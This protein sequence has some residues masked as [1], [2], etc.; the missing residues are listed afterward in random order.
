MAQHILSL[1]APDT[2]NK[3]I[4]RIVDTSV[5]NPLQPPTC[6]W[7]QITLPGFNQP[8][9]FDDTQISPGFMLNL[10]ACDLGLQTLGCGTTYNDLMDGI[11]IIKYSVSPNDLV[12]VE[13]N[14]LRITNALYMIQCIL[15]YLDISTC[16]PPEA[17]KDKMEELSIIREYLYAAKAK[18]EFCHEPSKGMDLYRYAVKL[19]NKAACN[20]GC[21]TCCESC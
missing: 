10:T 17:I 3:C 13:Y 2:M 7:L 12:Y 5:Y 11:Y 6:P 1:E 8:V 18:V 21:G 9:N 14:H 20:T 15:C 4:L 16:D 19:L